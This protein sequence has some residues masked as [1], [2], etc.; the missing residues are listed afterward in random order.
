VPRENETEAMRRYWDDRARE[1]AVFYVDTTCRYD[2]PDMERFFETGR[3][4]VDE[5]LTSAPV[6]PSRR[7]L[8]VEI[9]PGLGR[10]CRALGDQF[11]RVIGIDVSAEMVQRA[12]ELVPD[13]R[14]TFEVGDGATLAPLADASA[15]FVVTFT[16]LQH[17]TSRAA[18]FRYLNEAARV[19]RPGGVVAAQWNN[20]AHPWR[21]EARSLWWRLQ[22]RLG[23]AVHQDNRV[24]PQFLGTPVPYAAVKSTL[25]RAGLTVRGTKG[26]GTLFAWV[27]AEKK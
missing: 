27:W 7:Q 9:G 8:A 5:A 10:V 1:N 19:L 22:R 4:I 2:A 20:D 25:E 3:V 21:Y 13:P 14:I 26:E 23:V 12:R 6:Q 15:D 16:V 24:A 17:L 11:D 18:I